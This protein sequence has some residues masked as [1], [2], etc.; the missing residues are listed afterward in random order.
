MKVVF[1]SNFFNHHQAPFAK[2]MDILTGHEF[3][4]IETEP[5]HEE[6]IK[7]GWGTDGKPSYVYQSYISEEAKHKCIKLIEEAD[8]VI[9]G[10]CPFC[11]IKPRLKKNKLTFSYSERIFKCGFTGVDYWGRY[12]KWR[13]KLV[14]YQLSNHYLLCSSAYAADDYARMKLFVGKTYKWGYFPAF[15]K[16]D[17]EEVFRL[18][19]MNSKVSLLWVGRLITLKHPE[20]AIAVAK[21][22]KSEGYDFDLNIIGIGELEQFI[23]EMIQKEQ[24]SDC[25]HI[26]GAM[27]PEEVRG[28][29]KAADIFLFTSDFGEGW[30]AVLNEAMNSAC[31]VVACQA[32]GSVPFLVKEGENGLTYKNGDIDVLSCKVKQMIDNTVLRR[33]L[34]ERAYETL[35][36][37]WNAKVAAE[38]L[39]LMSRSLLNG[40]EPV[41]P[42]NGPCSVADTNI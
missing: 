42:E 23:K 26:L 32:I 37:T 12:F 6:R 31:A 11:M 18:K 40:E 13:V 8:V 34:G 4:F 41:C 33:K 27:R 30:G 36:G 1:A 10:S 28:Y 20:H 17:L 5:I 29:M 19:Q 25:V 38:R 21:Y 14:N 24:L 39:L 16:Y 15:E 3:S 22:L 9:C 2:E 7:L 35:E